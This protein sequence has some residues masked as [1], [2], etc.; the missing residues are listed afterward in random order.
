MDRSVLDGGLDRIASGT[1]YP[2]CGG[3]APRAALSRSELRVCGTATT[4][5]TTPLGSC[6]SLG[7][8][9]DQDM[10]NGDPVGSGLSRRTP[11]TAGLARR[12]EALGCI[13]SLDT[14]G[15]DLDEMERAWTR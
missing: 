14:P 6:W 1:S 12:Y 9:Q 15:L 7:P 4:P 5:G 3:R 13:G 10:H 8:G 2:I 11:T